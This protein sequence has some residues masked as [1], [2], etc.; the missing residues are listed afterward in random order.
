MQSA[1]NLPETEK[2]RSAAAVIRTLPKA[3]VPVFSR[4]SS[5]PEN[6]LEIT[7]PQEMMAERIPAQDTGTCSC[8]CIAGHAAPSRESG[9]P[10]L[11][12]DR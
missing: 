1:A 10:R 11:I 3:T 7:V 9:S 12:Y 5:L 8:G 2:P 4:R 6:R